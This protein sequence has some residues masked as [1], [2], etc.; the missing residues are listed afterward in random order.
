MSGVNNSAVGPGC[1]A[2]SSY[3]IGGING[4]ERHSIDFIASPSGRITVQAPGVLQKSHAIRK[5]TPAVLLGSRRDRTLDHWAPYV[6]N[7]P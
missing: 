3:A 1:S 5:T 7:C 2:S 6:Q 4:G